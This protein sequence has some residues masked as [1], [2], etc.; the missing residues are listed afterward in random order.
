VSVDQLVDVADDARRVDIPAEGNAVAQDAYSD[1][2]HPDYAFGWTW[3]ACENYLCDTFGFPREI[4]STL[5][6]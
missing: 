5:P 1:F 4:L 3:H 2:L 6:R